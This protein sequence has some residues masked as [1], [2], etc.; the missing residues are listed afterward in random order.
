MRRLMGTAILRRLAMAGVGATA[1]TAAM[2]P[3]AMAQEQTATFEIPAQRLSSGVRA[4]ASQ[5]RVSLA[6]P[7]DLFEG[8]N[9]P[10]V[11]GQMSVRTALNQLLAG[12]GLEAQFVSPDSVRIVRS[13]PG[14][15]TTQP[16]PANASEL[17]EIII[18]GSQIRGA[19]VNDALPV[20]VLDTEDLDGV[21]ATNGDELF[22]AIPQA[23]DVAFNESQDVGASMTRA[24]T[25]LRS[26]C[27]V[28]A[29][30]TP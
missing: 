16:A 5:A 10:A 26:I 8:L 17:D 9:G 4:L 12:S 30:A 7:S 19:R 1:L 20:T 11:N 25:R 13:A 29:P 22:R 3:V 18:V 15:I 23:A 27:V 14:V 21:A 2:A 6:A 24:V 28:W